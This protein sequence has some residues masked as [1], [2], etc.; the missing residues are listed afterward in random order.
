MATTRISHLWRAALAA[1]ALAGAG[2]ATTSIRSD[3]D[4][5]RDLTRMPIPSAVATERVDATTAADVS[6]LLRQPLTADAAVRIALL[7]NRE[8]RASLRELGVARGRLVQ[9]GLLPNPEIEVDL[10]HQQD[11]EQPLQAEILVEYDL[12]RALLAPKRADVARADLEAARYRAAAAVVETGYEV[13]AA[14]YG[15]QAALARLGIAVRA[16]DAF[17][18]ARD[19]A[20]AL[21]EAG[22]VPELDVATQ[23]AAYQSARATVA[24]LELAVLD[25]REQVQR[26]LGLHGDATGWTAAAALPP[27][28]ADLDLPA[29]IE[30]RALLASIELAEL[31]S[32]LEAIARRTGLA[33][34]EGWLPDISVD[35]HAE[36]DGPTWEVGGGARFTLPVFDRNQGTVAAH[37][38]EFDAL[39]ERYHGAAIDLRSAARE[40]RNRLL[41]AYAR[42]RQ[43]HEIIV[44]A[45]RRVV[46]QTLL[47]YN[48]MQI[49]VFQLLQARREELDA[50]LAH[51]GALHDFWTARAALDTLLAGRRV[52]MSPAAASPTGLAGSPEASGGH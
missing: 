3:L 22:N 48:A 34:T 39:M 2:C 14:F 42:A 25:R 33:R 1:L 32:R 24:Q 46:E 51:V 7:N 43:Y 28:P 47:Q 40:A 4:R 36:Q 45:R 29:G 35:V 10:R 23:E 49:G 31:R 30:R 41:A 20:S 16:L 21:F 50:E 52:G 18:A 12:T 19:A 9:A 17:A 37:E 6:D 13:R 26:L 11:R 5:V 38:A 27:V 8:L 15:L 44:P